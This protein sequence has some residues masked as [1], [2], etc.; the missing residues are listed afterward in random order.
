MYKE[1]AQQANNQCRKIL[2][3]NLDLKMIKA[4]SVKTHV[5]INGEMLQSV[6]HSYRGCFKNVKI[7]ARYDLNT[8]E[9]G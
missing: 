2:S 5:T 1:K 6:L 9:I 3:E 8:V 7:L 4:S